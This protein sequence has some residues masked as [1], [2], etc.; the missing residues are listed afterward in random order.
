MSALGAI[1]KEDSN[2][3]RLIHDCSRPRDTMAPLKCWRHRMS[4]TST[5]IWRTRQGFSSGV[6]CMNGTTSSSMITGAIPKEDS[7]SIRTRRGFSS[8]VACM[9]GTTSSSMITGAIS[10]EDSNSIRL[11]HDWSRPRDNCVNSYAIS[12]PF[13]YQ[14]LPEAIEM[15]TPNCYLAKVDLSQAYRIVKTHSSN[16]AAT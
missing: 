4:T 8:G 10:K 6:A 1:P 3:I 7:N 11:I 2:S 13:Q 14:T 16:H 9:N 5:C 12:D 15:I